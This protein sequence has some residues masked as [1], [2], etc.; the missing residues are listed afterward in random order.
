[1]ASIEEE[2]CKLIK[3]DQSQPIR[4]KDKSKAN[5][6]ILIKNSESDR[7][8]RIK[9]NKFSSMDRLG[10]LEQSRL[11]NKN[12]G[13]QLF[14]T[15]SDPVVEEKKGWRAWFPSFCCAGTNTN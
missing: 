9:N 7:D 8:N 13:R 4:L 2:G 10:G 1:M 6:Q 5:D 3:S 12:N 14:Q 11:A 15:E